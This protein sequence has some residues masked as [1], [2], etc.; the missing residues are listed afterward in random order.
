MTLSRGELI[1]V[2]IFGAI[3]LG[4]IACMICTSLLSSKS[5]I[6]VWFGIILGIVAILFEY[7]L[8]KQIIKCI[9]VYI[10][11]KKGEDNES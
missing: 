7:R 2:I 5:D 3:I 4:V 10:Q 11:E 1:I 6:A 9:K 8:V